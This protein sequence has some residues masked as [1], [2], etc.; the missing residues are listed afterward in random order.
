M[1]TYLQISWISLSAPNH[2]CGVPKQPSESPDCGCGCKCCQAAAKGPKPVSRSGGPI[3]Y[4]TGEIEI[5]AT[6][7]QAGGF[8]LPWGH[9]RS[10]ANRLT[11]DTNAGQGYNWQVAEWPYVVPGDDGS[12]AVMGN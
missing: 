2:A 7:L 1:P 5:Q 6:D 12:V 3:R 11:E 10:F 9:T 4:A 8:G